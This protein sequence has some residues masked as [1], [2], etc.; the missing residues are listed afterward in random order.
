MPTFLVLQNKKK[1]RSIK[2]ITTVQ[3]GFTPF[4]TILLKVFKNIHQLFVLAKKM[5]W[6][7]VKTNGKLQKSNR[8]G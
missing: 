3:M 6:R 1:T 4:I 5:R 2:Y 8:F 7:K